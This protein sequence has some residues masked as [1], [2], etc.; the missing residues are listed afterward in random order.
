MRPSYLPWLQRL[1]VYL[2]STIY[3]DRNLDV[4]K[5]IA[6]F[7]AAADADKEATLTKP[8]GEVD[9][10]KIVKQGTRGVVKFTRTQRPGLYTLQLPS[11][12]PIHYVVNADRRESNLA[13][14]TE[15]EIG[16]L[17]RAHNV[18]LVRSAAEYK[19]VEQKRR[20]GTELWKWLLWGLLIFVI[21]EMVL[22]QIFAGVRSRRRS[23]SPSSPL[24]SPAFIG[25][26]TR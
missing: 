7:T 25:G 10:S 22:Q 4:G 17:T 2:A 20:F 5:E 16:D 6:A 13:K 24:G 8:S 1:T 19:Q 11:G 26:S 3:P 18:S 23:S 15:K 21:G 9:K 14:L 12:A